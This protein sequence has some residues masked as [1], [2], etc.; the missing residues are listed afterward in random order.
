VAAVAVE[1]PADPVRPRKVLVA[2][3]DEAVAAWADL[4][5]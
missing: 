3:E 1:G 5:D 4:M 2:G